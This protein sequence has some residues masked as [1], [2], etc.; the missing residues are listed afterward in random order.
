M[1]LFLPHLY[2]EI[3]CPTLQNPANGRVTLTGVTFGSTATY[4]C[5]SGFVLV[6]D[7]ERMC[8]DSGEWS[9]D[10]PLCIGEPQA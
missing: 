2:T 9:G 3:E 8:Q 4:E 5:D 10:E 6:G 7:E 1:S